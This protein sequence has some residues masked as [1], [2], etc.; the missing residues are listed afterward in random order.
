MVRQM[1][2]HAKTTLAAALWPRHGLLRSFAL[3]L[4][5]NL[6][7]AASAWMKV[8]MWPVPMTMQT[9]AVLLI[10]ATCGARLGAA[11]VAATLVEAA[12]GLPVL[13]GAVPLLALGP[14]AGYLAGFLLAVAA[15]GLAADRGWTHR[16][17]PLLVALLAGEALIYLPGLAWLYGAFLHDARASVAA[18]LLA[19][20]PGEAAKLALAAAVIVSSQRRAAWRSGN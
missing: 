19:F 10:G 7:L 12:L 15:V 5:A 16:T 3:V 20:L 8:P 9:F 18:G 11:A 13:A 17:L 14:T 1:R 6:L 4:G 2:T